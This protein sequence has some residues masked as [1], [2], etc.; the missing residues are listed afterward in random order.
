MSHPEPHPHRP[1]HGEE[2][3]EP[4]GPGDG[5][6]DRPDDLS[7]ER[8]GESVEVPPDEDEDAEREAPLQREVPGEDESADPVGDGH[9]DADLADR[10][11]RA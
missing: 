9:S 4:L 7:P 2:G 5:S 1:R 11:R 6:D 3:T 10:L 8:S